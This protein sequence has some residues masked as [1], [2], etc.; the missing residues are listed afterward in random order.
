MSYQQ[1]KEYKK[2]VGEE[3]EWAQN[4]IGCFYA[5]KVKVSKYGSQQREYSRIES[6]KVFDLENRKQLI[7][8]RIF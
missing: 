2:D 6:T 4:S 7:I 3:K 5:L 1:N 8:T